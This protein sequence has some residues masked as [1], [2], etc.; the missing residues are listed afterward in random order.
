MATNIDKNFT[1][2]AVKAK[3]I[4]Q[5]PFMNNLAIPLTCA[6]LTKSLLG[7]I[8]T[9]GVF[10]LEKRFEDIN[11]INNYRMNRACGG[12]ALEILTDNDT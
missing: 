7:L 6:N 11:D 1:L 10:F 12:D 8:T 9:G 4:T 5:L 2:K 3:N